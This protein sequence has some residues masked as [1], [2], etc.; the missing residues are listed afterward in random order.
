MRCSYGKCLTA[1]YVQPSFQAIAAEVD[2]VGAPAPI[3]FA[4]IVERVMPAVVGVRV[5]GNLRGHPTKRNGR[6]LLRTS[7]LFDRFFRRFGIPIP[8]SPAPKSATALGSGFFISNDGYIVADNHVVAK[9]GSLEVTPRIAARRMRQSSSDPIR[10]Q[11][12]AHQR[13]RSRGFSV[14]KACGN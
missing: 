4:D 8:D 11:I 1:A 6:T 5:K 13:E 7:G 2:A 12:F 9:G 3:A 14:C 10:R